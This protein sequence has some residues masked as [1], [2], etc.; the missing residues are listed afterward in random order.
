M[1]GLR[2]LVLDKPAD[3]PMERMEG[4]TRFPTMMRPIATRH[5]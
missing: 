2:S 4:P 5:Y 1:P 3:R